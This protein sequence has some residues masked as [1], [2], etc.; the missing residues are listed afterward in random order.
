MLIDWTRFG[1]SGLVALCALS[2]ASAA[3]DELASGLDRDGMNP[4]I[5]PQD[6]LFG[7]MN[8][9]WLDQTPIPPDK[10]EYGVLFQLRDKSDE[11]V[12]ALIEELAARK[13]D[14]DSV[15]GKVAFLFNDTATTE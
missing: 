9:K 6:D 3:P 5:R 11:R 7:A 14:P 10:A 13:P 8:G 12:K 4:A 15:P 1:A 2:A